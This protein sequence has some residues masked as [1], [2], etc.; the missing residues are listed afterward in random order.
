MAMAASTMVQ[1]QISYN[2]KWIKTNEKKK[3]K[4]GR[5]RR[6][7]QSKK[8][9]KMGT[10]EES[11]SSS[12]FLDLFSSVVAAPAVRYL[13][14]D[15]GELRPALAFRDRHQHRPP[16]PPHQQAPEARRNGP[17]GLNGGFRFRGHDPT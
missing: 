1:R 11:M 8:M 12:G 15:D 2:K 9:N 13:F 16:A 5:R 7:K 17:P 3:P 6:K 10:V 4:R 14:L